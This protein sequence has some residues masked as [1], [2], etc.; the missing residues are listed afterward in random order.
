MA[1]SDK[2]PPVRREAKFG[3]IET[4]RPVSE[5][6]LKDFAAQSN[7]INDFQTDYHQFNL[8]GI[9]ATAV[10]QEAPDGS[11]TFFYNASIVGITHL[12]QRTGSSG[13]T[14][15]DIVW[16]D[17]S[18]VLQG[19]IFSTKPSISFSASDGA[20]GFKNLVT[21][22]ELTQ[23]GVTLPVFSKSTFLE[24]ERIELRL[25]SSASGT[26]NASLHINSRPEN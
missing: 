21:N 8:N 17:Q 24:G 20:R 16:Y 14:E 9:F 11:Y 12:V 18:N 23:T 1:A 6:T 22:T 2:I 4:N 15:F 25:I 26:Q 3:D 19:S 10:T 13:V 5:G 7:F